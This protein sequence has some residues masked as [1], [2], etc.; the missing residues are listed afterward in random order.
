MRLIFSLR[1]KLSHSTKLLLFPIR[2]FAERARLKN[3][4]IKLTPSDRRR[5]LEEIT[6]HTINKEK[7][8]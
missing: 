4:L 3:E 6:Y 7:L 8:M 2:S 1:A 5:V